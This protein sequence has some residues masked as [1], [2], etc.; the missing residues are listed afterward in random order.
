MLATKLGDEAAYSLTRSAIS[1][2]RA[3]LALAPTVF[4]SS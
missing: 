2:G 4:T 1:S 3:A